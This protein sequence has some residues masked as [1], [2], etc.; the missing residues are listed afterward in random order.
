M[1][2]FRG[3]LVDDMLIGMRYAER[4]SSGLGFTFNDGEQVEGITSTLYVVVVAFLNWLGLPTVPIAR[5]LT[6]V[7]VLL[8]GLLVLRASDD[9]FRLF[10]AGSWARVSWPALCVASALMASAPFAVWVVGGI[11]GPALALVF[12][13][14]TWF[15]VKVDPAGAALRFA[16]IVGV[17]LAAA[18]LLRPEG[19]LL[20]AVVTALLLFR[21]AVSVSSRSDRL[22]LLVLLAPPVLVVAGLTLWRSWYFGALLPNTAGVKVDLS[23][24]YLRVGFRYV[25]SA[26]TVLAPVIAV[27]MFYALTGRRSRASVEFGHADVAP[28]LRD[29][30]WFACLF[31]GVPWCVYLVWVGGDWM[32]G[33]RQMS[34]LFLLLVLASLDATSAP[35]GRSRALVVVAL[36]VA[37]TAALSLTARDSRHAFSA[38]RFMTD[39]RE[40]SL[41]LREAFKEQ[42]PLLAV[43]PAGCP[44]YYTGFTTLDML[45]LADRHIAENGLDPSARVLTWDEWQRDRNANRGVSTVHGFMVAHGS[46]DG[47]YVW[48]S[49]PDLFVLCDPSGSEEGCFRSW[50]EMRASFDVESRYVSQRVFLG[51]DRARPWRFWIRYDAGPLGVVS[52]SGDSVV[53]VPYWLLTG[54]G[55]GLSS[56]PTGLLLRVQGD[57][58]FPPVALSAGSWS[59]PSGLFTAGDSPGCRVEGSSGRV[60]SDGSCRVVFE[61]VGDEEVDPFAVL[62]LHKDAATS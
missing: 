20:A 34:V 22:R 4:I 6:F 5:A 61:V 12:A 29:R 56:G 9:E 14:A 13:A 31:V 26:V 40:G 41:V 42:M 49:E 46:G 27:F 17:I 10:R 19:V 43:E 8:S 24:V 18:C 59:Y 37:S 39:C 38:A 33:F 44:P 35:P 55:T 60:V 47:A 1:W 2:V 36:A 21:G 57:A 7:T 52:A 45:G 30:V 54:E 51:G 28:R 53:D 11:D 15:S 48:S 16:G 32:P 50:K 3:F 58:A 25:L 62:R 23:V